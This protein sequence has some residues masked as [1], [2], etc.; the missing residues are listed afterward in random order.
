MGYQIIDSKGRLILVG[1]PKQGDNINI[2]SLP[3]HFGKIITGSHGGESIP[4]ND[5]PRYLN[6]FENRC[7]EYRWI[8]F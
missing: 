7:L 3:L 8:N 1:V 5:I 2:F 4:N 6:L